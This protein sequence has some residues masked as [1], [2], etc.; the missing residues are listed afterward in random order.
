MQDRIEEFLTHLE[1]ERGYSAHTRQAYRRDLSFFRGPLSREGIRAYFAALRT[2]RKRASGQ[3]RAAASLRSFLRFLGRED[4]L[5]H[6]PTPKIPR[7]L[8]NPLSRDQV[9]ALLEAPSSGPLAARDRALAELLYAC[10]LRASEVAALRRSDAHLDAGYV[11]CLGKGSKERVIPLG[12][13]A[14]E[15]LAAYLAEDPEAPS[16]A[17]L[18]RSL[19]GGPLARETVWRI[20]RKLARRGGI[21]RRAYPHAVRHSFATHLV[22]NGADLRYVQEMLGHAKISTTQI[23]TQ[24]DQARLK[25]V[26]RRHHPRA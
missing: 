2:C 18:F 9:K 15:A 13:P 19:R 7:L 20:V 3:A 21:G 8:P 22:E 1:V 4:L 10:G 25:T 12:R 24:V 16:D 11:R 26:H 5:S 6:V 23:Y 14:R 17:P